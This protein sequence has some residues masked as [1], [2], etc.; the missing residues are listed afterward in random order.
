MTL[1]LLDTQVTK[2]PKNLLNAITIGLGCLP[3]SNPTSLAVI[4]VLA[5]KEATQ[6]LLALLSHFSQA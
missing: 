3:T 2:K 4:G 6:S 5:S 1:L